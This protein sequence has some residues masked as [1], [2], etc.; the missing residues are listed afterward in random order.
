MFLDIATIYCKAGDGGN[1]AVSFHREK[2]ISAG[3]PDGGDGGD[4]G[5]IYFVGS[6][7]LNTLIDFRFSQHFRA[8]NGGNG[9]GSNCKG[10]RGK[11]LILKVPRG[12]VIKDAESGGIIADVY[13]TDEKVLILSGGKGG[14]GNARFATSTRK[15]PAF[16][17]N[18]INSVER[19][20]RLEL[21]TIADVGLV[22]FPNVGKST[23]LSIIS[24]AKP[25][26]AN[27]HFTTLQP[28]LGVV[29]HYD[30]SFVVADIP[31]LIEGASEGLGLGHSFL[32]H[33]E[34]V[35][36]IVHLVDI[37]G[38]EMRNPIED[39][40]KIRKELGNYSKKLFDLP[41]IVVA[42]KC[43]LVEDEGIFDNFERQTGKKLIKITAITKMGVEELIDII[44]AKLK[45]MPPQQPL[46]FEP[47]IY[48]EEDINAYEIT[49]ENGIYYI[50]GPF[51]EELARKSY[52]DDTDSFNWFQIKMRE[53][54]IIK[55]LRKRGAEN[56]DTVDILGMEFEL[57]D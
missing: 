56:G 50:T 11:D 51:V 55:D 33:I 31:G 38:C 5:N 48:D 21:K 49:F 7:S 39:Y 23:L 3:G 22:G 8:E 2:Y 53:R 46:E 32:R 29:K 34:R 20:F 27:Y 4:G 45:D 37:S 47:F 41:E 15:A 26:I 28:N 18:G 14:R 1:G 24:S 35:R 44:S 42:N 10:K 9:Q 12:T 13:N 43:D 54:G 6:D 52:L 57:M 16:A 36:L 40:Q 19:K 17:E 25:K 30:D